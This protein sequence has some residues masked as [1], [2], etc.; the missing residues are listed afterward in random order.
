M[1][2]GEACQTFALSQLT[3]PSGGFAFIFL[4]LA[5]DAFHCAFAALAGIL[6][7]GLTSITG[8]FV[9]LF[10]AVA[11]IRI[12]FLTPLAQLPGKFVCPGAGFS[13]GRGL[14]PR[15]LLRGQ[16]LLRLWL[17]RDR[18]VQWIYP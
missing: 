15:R 1:F 4:Y 8:S 5:A 12:D 13:R 17:V 16:V 18:A 2:G 10:A 14:Q 9:H 6:I 7:H 3:F 11:D